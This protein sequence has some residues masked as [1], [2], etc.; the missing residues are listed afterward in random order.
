MIKFLR[1]Y[2]FFS[3]FQ[4]QIQREILSKKTPYG[5]VTEKIISLA[6]QE[7][8][9]K[10]NHPLGIMRYKLQSFFEDKQIPKGLLQKNQHTNYLVGDS[11]S[12][13]I[14]VQKNFED[15]LI[16]K[17]H[18]SRKRSDTYYVSEDLIMRPQATANERDMFEQKQNA[19]IIFT[20]CFRRDEIDATHYP[21]FHQMEA[22]RIFQEEDFSSN[23]PQDTKIQLVM[24]DL[25]QT[26][27]SL[28]KFIFGQDI[29]CRWIPAYFPFTEP[30]MELEI[31]YNN[32]WME[33]LGC[34]ILRP[35]ILQN[36]GRK[37]SDIAWASG[38][39]LERFAMLLFDIPDI[40][41]FWSQDQ[42]F[43]NQFQAGQIHKFIPFS[44]YPLCYKD[45]SFWVNKSQCFE[46]ND[47]HEICRELGGDLIESVVCQ[48]TFINKKINRTSKCYR[49]SYRSLERTL[50]NQ[51]V[52]FNI[53]IYLICFIFQIDSIQFQIRDQIQSKLGFELR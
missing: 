1:R 39:G 36:F 19:F 48:D 14:S 18:V 21:V 25:Q 40:R 17:D 43:L 42:R 6:G 4:K 3:T 12:P 32:Q 5:N 10:P 44:K 35:Q 49:V 29:Q 47:L 16:P 9:K 23:T 20:D 22:V 2:Y 34:G 30:S 7:L 33:M 13:L 52:F 27:E 51:E 41:L 24:Q 53:F 26:Y 28:I 11:F 15:L 38:C 45:V 46:E 50:T 31:F 8:H 37:N